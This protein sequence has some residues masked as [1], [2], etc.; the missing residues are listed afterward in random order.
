MK[1]HSSITGE[2]GLMFLPESTVH[3]KYTPKTL[4][5]TGHREIYGVFE[6]LPKVSLFVTKTEHFRESSRKRYHAVQNRRYAAK[7]KTH[8]KYIVVT[9]EL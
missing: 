9:R 4:Q 5:G 3:E 7:Y 6:G 8:K 2:K 1:E